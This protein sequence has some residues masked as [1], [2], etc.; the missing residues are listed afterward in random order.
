MQGDDRRRR[1]LNQLSFNLC[2]PRLQRVQA[3][4]D[5][6]ARKDAIGDLVDLAFGAALHLC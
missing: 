3:L 4:L 1:R 5:C 2:P 6:S